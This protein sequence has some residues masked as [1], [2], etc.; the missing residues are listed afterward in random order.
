MAT[1]LFALAIVA[2]HPVFMNQRSFVNH[3]DGA[4]GAAAV[5]GAAGTLTSSAGWVNAWVYTSVLPLVM[6]LL[7]IG[8]GAWTVA[9][10]NDGMLGL[11]STLP[12]RRSTIALQKV[13][14]MV[15]VGVLLAALVA[16]SVLL[17]E[18]FDVTIS[19]RPLL[20]TSAAVVLLGADFGLIAMAI[21]TFTRSRGRAISVAAL[22][23]AASYAVS[24]LAPVS[25]AVRPARYASLFY[26]AVQDGQI[27]HGVSALGFAVLG[28]V[29][30][31]ALTV[32]LLAFQRLDLD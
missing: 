12:V 6:L 4:G 19:P 15:A 16:A 23:A 26:W 11:V 24:A 25:G 7:T 3:F 2:L 1:A 20:T 27:T 17:G 13:A 28:G 9:G 31:I 22:I 30:V 14:A 32:T 5:F 18:F 8:Y 21:G 10:Q 29:L